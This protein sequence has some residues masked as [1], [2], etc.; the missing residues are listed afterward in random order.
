MGQIHISEFQ[1]EDITEI[2]HLFYATVQQINRADYSEEAIAAWAPVEEKGN[3][4]KAW[5]HSLVKNKTLVAKTNEQIAGFI[6]IRSDGYLDRLYV[7]KDKQRIGIA[8]ALLT[9]IEKWALKEGVSFIWTF[10]S[11]TA[12]GF[13]EKHGFEVIGKEDVERKGVSL[14]RYKMKKILMEG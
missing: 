7:H 9:E 10:S 13:F 1:Q 11:I 12:R 14:T 6:D 2:I 5:E 8:S 3:L 4:L